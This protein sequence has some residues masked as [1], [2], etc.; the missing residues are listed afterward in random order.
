[1]VRGRGNHPP[2]YRAAERR[3][4]AHPVGPVAMVEL[5]GSPHPVRPGLHRHRIFQ[6]LRI[7]GA[8]KAPSPDAPQRRTVLSA[9]APAR[10]MDRDPRACADRPADMGPRQSPVGAQRCHVLPAQQEERLPAAL[11]TEVRNLRAGHPRI[12]LCSSKRQVGPSLLQMRWHGRAHDGTGY[13]VSAGS[14]RCWRA[15]TGSVGPRRRPARQSVPAI[16]AV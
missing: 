4:V 3:G 9:P 1:M 16:G 15:G 13:A 7:R 2:V 8:Q 11:S 14:H 6:P 12:L 5:G 10:A